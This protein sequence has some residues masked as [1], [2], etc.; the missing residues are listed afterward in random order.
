MKLTS[1]GTENLIKR[2]SLA[3]FSDE[4]NG[5]E[6]SFLQSIQSKLLKDLQ[7]VAVISEKQYHR[8]EQVFEKTGTYSDDN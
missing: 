1:Q 3:L 5:W 4:L 2:I 7:G 6:M 8:L